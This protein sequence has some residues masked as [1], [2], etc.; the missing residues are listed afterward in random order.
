MSKK[1]YDIVDGAIPA[2]RVSAAASAIE[3]PGTRDIDANGKLVLPDVIGAHLWRTPLFRQTDSVN[4]T[5][6]YHSGKRA[7][8]YA[9]RHGPFLPTQIGKVPPKAL[10]PDTHGGLSRGF[11]RI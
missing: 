2:E 7:A 10:Q 9:P 6:T 3:D 1:Y 8:P 5:G 4:A 11:G